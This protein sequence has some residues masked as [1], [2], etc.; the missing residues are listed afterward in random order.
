MQNWTNNKR[1]K[2]ELSPRHLLDIPVTTGKH[3]T[4]DRPR[5]VHTACHQ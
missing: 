3:S 4:S 1:D 2:C 5:H